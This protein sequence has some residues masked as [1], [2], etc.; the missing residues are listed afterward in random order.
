MPKSGFV[1]I[2]GRPNAGKSTLLNRILGSEVSIVTPKAQTTRERVLGI[3]TE[4][5]RGQIIFID[6]PGIHSA[7]EGGINAAMMHEAREALVEPSL[8]WYLLDPRSSLKHETAVLDLLKD[9]HAPILLLVN[10]TDLKSP[11]ANTLAEEV[12]AEA[13][14]R[15]LNI[16]AILPISAQTGKGVQGL[17]DQAWGYLPEGPFYYEDPDQISD[18]PVRFFVAEKIRE[19]LFLQLGDELPYS[20]AVQIEKFDE[21]TRPWRIEAVIHVERESQQGIVVG[22]GGQKIKSIGQAARMEIEKFIGQRIFLGLKVKL[23]KN[24]TKDAALL[25]RMGYTLPDRKH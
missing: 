22:K 19:Q 3:L 7:K 11:S 5:D 9:N 6:T 21:S 2:I 25:K 17:I 4:P 15:G 8:I 13:R 24:W 18:R 1:A 20:C 16:E 23:L 10:K 14:K 12:A